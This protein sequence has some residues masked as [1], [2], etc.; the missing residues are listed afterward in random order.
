MPAATR[1]PPP[2]DEVYI[3]PWRNARFKQ[4]TS[5]MNGIP[6]LPKRLRAPFLR[7]F[8]SQGPETLT[9]NQTLFIGS[10][11]TRICE[12][13][14]GSLNPQPASFMGRRSNDSRMQW[15]SNAGSR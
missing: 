14:V 7:F 3:S 8:L 15:S 11:P 13:M 9:L 10:T 2:V 6:Y 5:P 12:Y 4:V 1:R